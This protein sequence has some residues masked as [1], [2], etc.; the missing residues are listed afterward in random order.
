MGI[1]HTVLNRIMRILELLRY[2]PLHEDD[3]DLNDPLSASGISI[4]PGAGLRWTDAPGVNARRATRRNA[5]DRVL[6][7]DF[8]K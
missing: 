6:P 3:A 8:R 1:G 7:R 2:R 4:A 5:G